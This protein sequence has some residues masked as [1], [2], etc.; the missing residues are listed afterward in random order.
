MIRPLRK[1]HA[2]AW[3]AL[4]LCLPAGIALGLGARPAEPTMELTALCTAPREPAAWSRQGRWTDQAILVRLAAGEE[5]TIVEVKPDEDRQ[6]PV[7]LV[8]WSAEAPG[9]SLPERAYLLGSLSGTEPRRLEL[10]AH[11]AGGWLHLLSLGHGELVSSLELAGLP[12]HE[13]GP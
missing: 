13:A 12:D 7:L 11:A 9:G 8:Y 5:R 6:K 4:A 10:P 1:A 2:A 3:S